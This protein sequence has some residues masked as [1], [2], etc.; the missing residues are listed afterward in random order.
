M[1]DQLKTFIIVAENHSFN[2]AANQ[3]FISAP[4]VIKQI[5][6]LERNIK[7]SLFN[8]THNGVTLTKAG[9]SFYQDAKKIIA[10]YDQSVSR[11]QDLSEE[12]QTVKIGAGPLATGVGTNNLWLEISKKMPNITF[13]FIPCSCALGN[14][15]E[16]LAGINQNFDLV[17]SVYDANLLD[18]FNLD[19]TALDVTPLKLSV[20]IQNS[21]SQK[22]TL[23]LD[24]LDGQTIALTVKGEFSCFDQVRELLKNKSNIK[25]H[26]ISGIDISALNDCVKNNWILC[27]ADDWQAAHP[28]LKAK[29]VN[30][31]C[32]APFGLVYGKKHPTVIDKI[33]N[34]LQK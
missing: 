32:S 7:V 1:D 20:P 2:K 26:D 27:S 21:L 23:N 18:K 4:A 6:A 8:R 31:N 13:Q 34:Y 28:M 29:N 9:K 24:D 16:F 25:I 10:A 11:A 5:N 33:L 15:N 19:A 12:I 14:F 22:E 30:W 17:S 3:L